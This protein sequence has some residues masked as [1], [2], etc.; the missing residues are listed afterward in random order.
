MVALGRQLLIRTPIASLNGT[1][2]MLHTS[3]LSRGFLEALGKSIGVI[4][5][6]EIGDK[7]FFIAAIMAMRN[8][9]WTVIGGK[10]TSS[11]LCPVHPNNKQLVV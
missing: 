3:Q 6:S 8:P 1:S 2:S 7:T 9:K 5:A 4:G 11:G 10:G